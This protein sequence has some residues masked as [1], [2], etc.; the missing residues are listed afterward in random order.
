V[1]GEHD[2]HLP[3][4]FKGPVRLPNDREIVFRL[5]ERTVKFSTDHYGVM[6]IADSG[7]FIKF[8]TERLNKVIK[9]MPQLILRNR[10][11][12]AVTVR[13]WGTDDTTIKAEKGEPV[14]LD[15]VESFA[16]SINGTSFTERLP[17]TAVKLAGYMM[18]EKKN[19]VVLLRYK[20]RAGRFA[21][22]ELL[23]PFVVYNCL[24]KTLNLQF[25]QKAKLKSTITV[26]A[27]QSYS[28]F[29]AEDV[30]SLE[31]KA[32]TAG[33]TWSKKFKHRVESEGEERL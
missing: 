17:V 23:P 10:L 30:R 27:Q 4:L 14:P 5:R 20:E 22:L 32:T 31:L 25:L 6:K 19:F 9:F 24:P 33:F 29:T 21:V 16:V 2:F 15:G 8:D 3:P 11:R 13:R 18:A 12:Q 26:P 1:R 7:F 28:I